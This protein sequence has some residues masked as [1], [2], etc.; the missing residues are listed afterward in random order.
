MLPVPVYYAILVLC[1]AYAVMRGGGP[2]RAGAA[3]IFIGS[4]CSTALLSAGPNR[5]SGVESG[6]FA[7]D[8]AV[9]I[10]FLVLALRANRYWP[11]WMTALQLIGTAEHAVKMV[12]SH[13][14]RLVYGF[15]MA[16]WTYPMLL[17]LV[18]GTW[19]HRRRLDRFGVDK[20]WASSSSP[21]AALPLPGRRG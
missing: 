9:C 11:L 17:L 8:G 10:A 14:I 6:V 21:S 3:I 16:V 1:A 20:S 4:V 7:V 18:L 2:E 5:Y 13:V 12:D 19:R 15:I